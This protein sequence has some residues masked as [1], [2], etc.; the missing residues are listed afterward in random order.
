MLDIDRE[1]VRSLWEDI[2]T[3]VEFHLLLNGELEE[4]LGDLEHLLLKIERN[5]VVDDLEETLS[6]ASLADLVGTDLHPCGLAGKE[7][8]EVNDRGDFGGRH[9][10]RVE[11]RCE[12]KMY[13]NVKVV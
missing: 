12:C 11:D 9:S 8:A 7:V 4:L 5:G 10:G 6:Q 2:I 1:R 13:K 3:F